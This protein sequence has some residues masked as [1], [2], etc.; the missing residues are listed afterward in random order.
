MKIDKEEV[1][2]YAIMALVSTGFGYLL[3]TLSRA[4]G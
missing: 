4:L 1:L 3:A 2:L